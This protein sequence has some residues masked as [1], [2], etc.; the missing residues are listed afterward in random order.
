MYVEFSGRRIGRGRGT[1][2]LEGSDPEV[3]DEIGFDPVYMI[4]LDRMATLPNGHSEPDTCTD[5]EIYLV[6]Q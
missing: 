1:E 6:D 4:A 5:D 3:W 2:H